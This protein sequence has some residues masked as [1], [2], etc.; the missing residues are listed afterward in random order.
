V[1]E[2]PKQAL[3]G[4]VIYEYGETK[5]PK[6]APVGKVIY[7]YGEIYQYYKQVCK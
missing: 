1:A 3:V 5:Y 6:Q 7:E 2:Y 4:T